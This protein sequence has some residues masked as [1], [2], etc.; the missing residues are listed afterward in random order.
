MRRTALLATLL[1]LSTA[2][3][4]E[5]ATH[6]RLTEQAY[7][8]SVLVQDAKLFTDIGLDPT[9]NNPF[10]NA[11]FDVSGSYARE[12]ATNAFEESKGRMPEG[13]APYSIAGWLMRGAI[14]EDDVPWPFGEGNPQD[15]PY[16][17]IFRVFNHFYD[18]VHDQPLNI[19]GVTPGSLLGQPNLIAPQWALGSS[20]VFNLPGTPD[21]QRR[22]HFTAFDAREAISRAH[23]DGWSVLL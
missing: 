15:D 20:D 6:S 22:N 5:L 21:S 13:F 4:Y 11:Y 9:M 17:N 16:G 2:N 3:G 14:R 8:A 12:R 7:L 18:P 19:S 10:G 1:S 23:C